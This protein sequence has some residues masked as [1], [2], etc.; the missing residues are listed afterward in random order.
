MS[1]RIQFRERDAVDDIAVLQ[2]VGNARVDVFSFSGKLARLSGRF[3][4][5]FVS[6]LIRELL[7][8]FLQRF[9]ADGNQASL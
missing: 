1:K 8:F 5:G 2:N 4:H 9:R 3:V 7:G 6:A